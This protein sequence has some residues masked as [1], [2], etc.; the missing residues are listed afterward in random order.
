MAVVAAVAKTTPTPAHADVFAGW[1]EGVARMLGQGL[2]YVLEVRKSLYQIHGNTPASCLTPA[3]WASALQRGILQSSLSA[4]LVYGTYYHVYHR[5]SS[6]QWSAMEANAFATFL[7]SLIKIPLSNSIRWVQLNPMKSYPLPAAFG[8]I[9]K[10]SGIRGLYSGYVLSYIEDFIE[11]A[12]RDRMFQ[13]IDRMHHRQPT[14]LLKNHEIGFVGGALSGATVAFLTTPFDTLRCH[15]TYLS[16]KQKGA[17]IGAIATIFTPMHTTRQLIA[18]HG[19]GLFYRGASTRAIST[20]LRMAFF[21]TFV[22]IL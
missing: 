16:A 20:G 12:L 13:A 5:C 9:Y 8:H 19:I 14:P 11:M 4:G 18:D 7:T 6:A 15:L 10:T 3:Q 17:N 2:T 22:K 1:K 21:Y